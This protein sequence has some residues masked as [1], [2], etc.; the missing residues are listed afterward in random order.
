MVDE[1]AG[2]R[3][4]DSEAVAALLFALSALLVSGR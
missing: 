1:E 2:E 4:D 3:E